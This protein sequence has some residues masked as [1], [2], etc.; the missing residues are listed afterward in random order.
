[1][2]R[3]ISFFLKLNHL[4]VKNSLILTK[5]QFVMV[6]KNLVSYKRRLD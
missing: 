5:C 6:I 1:M 2:Q 4:L 3:V